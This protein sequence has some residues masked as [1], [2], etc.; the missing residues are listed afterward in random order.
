M[1]SPA[2]TYQD[3]Q[4][5]LNTTSIKIPSDDDLDLLFHCWRLTNCESC[6]SSSYPCSWCSVSSTCVP[7]TIFKFPFQ[8]LAPI[9]TGSICPL[10]WRERWELRAK[11]FSCRCSTMTLMSVVV[12]VL[13]TLMAITLIQIL[14]VLLRCSVRRWKKR[15]VGWWRVHEWRPSMPTLRQRQ[16]AEENEEQRDE[17]RQPLLNS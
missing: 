15:Q 3:F 2:R 17:E 12:A 4:L 6:L 1:D 10:S 14:V 7:N 5:Y 16:Q 9:K 11:P 13:S 8:I